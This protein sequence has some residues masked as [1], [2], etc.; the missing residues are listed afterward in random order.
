MHIYGWDE[1]IGQICVIFKPFV[2]LNRVGSFLFSGGGQ[3]CG[4][5]ESGVSKSII[6]MMVGC[7]EK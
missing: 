1:R 6:V 4:G 3:S 2:V 5:A 7:L